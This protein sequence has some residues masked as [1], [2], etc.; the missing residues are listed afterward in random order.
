MS[1][2]LGISVEYVKSVNEILKPVFLRHNR[3]MSKED[4]L[5]WAKAL[6]M[7]G[8]EIKAFQGAMFYW[9]A[10]Q[11]FMPFPIDI[12][13]IANGQGAGNRG[14]RAIQVLREKV[15]NIG[16][17]RKPHIEDPVLQMTIEDFGGWKAIC[18]QFMDDDFFR[19]RFLKAYTNNQKVTPVL[20]L[21]NRLCLSDFPVEQ[22]PGDLF[23]LDRP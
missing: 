2:D 4:L 9:L 16:P 18:E 19:N 20:G 17:Y 8:V 3:E 11:R 23:T 15:G 10:T 6:Q 12:A 14:M 7:H 22:N 13:D 1:T 5:L 21:S